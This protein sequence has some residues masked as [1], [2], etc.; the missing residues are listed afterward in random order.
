MGKKK[1]KKYEIDYFNMS[2]EEQMANA[3]LFHEVETG[4]VS[5][6]DALNYN[7]PS[8]PVAQSDYTRQ[9]ERAC[10]GMV[11]DKETYDEVIA[12]VDAIINENIEEIIDV[13]IN[14]EPEIVIDDNIEPDDKISETCQS[15]QVIINKVTNKDEDCIPR[16]RFHYEPI[17][18]RMMIDDGLISTAVSVCHSSS[19]ELDTDHIPDDSDEFG[20][21]ISKIYYYIIT[22]KHP[23]VIMSEDTFEI[24]FSMYSK[25]DFNK[26]IFF[27]NDGFVYA[28]VIDDCDREN[29]YSV[30]EIFNMDNDD[31]LRYVVGAA[32]AANTIHN[33][34]MYEDEDEVTSVMDAR[35][36]VKELIKL[37]DNDSKTEYAGH[38]SSGDVMS[39]MKVNDFQSFTNDIRNILES[40]ILDDEYEDDDEDGEYE[41]EDDVDIN[42]FPDFDTPVNTDN[43][44]EMFEELE[45]S[46]DIVIEEKITTIEKV[47]TSSDDGSMVLPVIHRRQ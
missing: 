10:L 24:E 36:S 22:R 28:Y 29:F 39:R 38:N 15:S 18:G 5:F 9:I 33:V 25:I 27:K 46:D 44:D 13:I 34:F 12:E 17:V 40:L 37:I 43:I 1:N 21:L 6:L 26:F 20:S 31:L 4:E 14:E 41:E 11:D 3:E 47:E 30:V 19:I 45:S 2:P 16:I 7:V 8:A 23:A 35:H 42:D 32:Y